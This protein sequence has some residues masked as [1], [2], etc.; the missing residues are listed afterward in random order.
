[1]STEIPKKWYSSSASA[2]RISLTLKGVLVGLIPLF[3]VAGKSVGLEL[4]QHE[5][6]QTIETVVALVSGGMVL[7]GLAR[8]FFYRYKNK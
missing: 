1:M 4:T 8:K 2:E 5:L 3:I 7:I 6:M